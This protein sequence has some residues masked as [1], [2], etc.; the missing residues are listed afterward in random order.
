MP[1]EALALLPHPPRKNWKMRAQT[2]ELLFL[3]IADWGD[4]SVKEAVELRQRNAVL[5]HALEAAWNGYSEMSPEGFERGEDRPL[6]NEMLAA[7]ERE[8]RP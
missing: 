6:R 3:T 7:I 4:R 5:L 8:R 2:Y 1:D